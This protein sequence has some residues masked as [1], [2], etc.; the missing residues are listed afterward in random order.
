[1]VRFWTGLLKTSPQ[2][3]LLS[4]CLALRVWRVRR[5]ESSMGDAT[6][7]KRLPSPT[8]RKR[9]RGRGG[10]YVNLDPSQ[11]HTFVIWAL[12]RLRQGDSLELEGSFMYTAGADLNKQNTYKYINKKT[13]KGREELYFK[14]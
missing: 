3:D 7:H 11:W 6:Y 14:I 8:R 5:K 2:P 1:M 13:S 9:E 4:S 12:G 10:E